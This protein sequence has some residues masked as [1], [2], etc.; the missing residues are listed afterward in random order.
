M[1]S[2]QQL[3][4][5]P[6]DTIFYE[7]LPWLPVKSLLRFKSV[8]KKW[9]FFIS[10]EYLSR[11]Q[12]QR[13]SSIPRSVL[14]HYEDFKFQAIN[15]NFEYKFVGGQNNSVDLKVLD[16]LGFCNTFDEVVNLGNAAD[17]MGS[18]NGLLCMF[19]SSSNEEW[20]NFYVV[21]NPCIGS[22]IEIKDHRE[23]E[24]KELNYGF[25]YVTMLDDYEIVNV[26]F[27]EGMQDAEMVVS[28]YSLR[29]KEWRHK[30][31]EKRLDFDKQP[32]AFSKFVGE[33]VKETLYWGMIVG[34]EGAL[35]KCIFAFDLAKEEFRIMPLPK[36]NLGDDDGVRRWGFGLCSINDCLF[37]W[38]KYDDGHLELW[39]FKE[40]GGV[41]SWTKL[42]APNLMENL[43]VQDCRDLFLIK[44]SG[45][46][47]ILTG[48][49][50]LAFADM[51]HDPPEYMYFDGVKISGAVNYVYSLVSP[52]HLL[53]A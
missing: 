44:E 7:I 2:A 48:A 18:C 8:C 53:L 4:E 19:F 37:A 5:L 10:S 51:N 29:S 35:K 22:C 6:E 47:L 11:I 49:D 41:E 43:G 14:V 33:L 16:K 28:V 34:K 23:F 13:S 32:W 42:W 38:G 36:T 52:I 24:E 12:L 45:K 30:F 9:Y 50:A 26:E 1:R 46:I 27:V 39:K 31:V 20:C 25:G 17:L 40:H 3:I 15:F 21:Y